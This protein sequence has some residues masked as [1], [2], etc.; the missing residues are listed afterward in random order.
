MKAMGQFHIPTSIW[1][2]LYPTTIGAADYLAL[3]P[4]KAMS[5]GTQGQEVIARFVKNLNATYVQMQLFVPSSFTANVKRYVRIEQTFLL[6][7]NLAV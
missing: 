1:N 5:D 4:I 6:S 3:Q 7:D 2:K